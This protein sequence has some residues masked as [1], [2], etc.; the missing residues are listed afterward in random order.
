V[1]VEKKELL[2]VE[3]HQE[4]AEEIYED[5]R[6][7]FDHYH[8]A[9]SLTEARI[10]IAEHDFDM[11]I[12][13]PFFSDGSGREFIAELKKNKKLYTTP[14]IVVCNLPGKKAKLDFYSY[15]AD[16]YFQIPYDKEYFRKT[17]E[18][19]LKRHIRLLIHQGR[20]TETG[21]DSRMSFEENLKKARQLIA[22]NKENGFLGLIAPVAIDFVIRDFGLEAGDKLIKTTIGLMR[23]M[24]DKDLSV[25]MWTQK[26]I[27]FSIMNKKE[28]DIR[29]GLEEVRLSYLKEMKEISKLQKSPG[30]RAVIKPISADKTLE[31]QVKMLVSNLVSISKDKDAVPIQ[32]FSEHPVHK[33][34]VVLADPDQVSANIISYRLK[35]EG[36]TPELIDDIQDIIHYR[37]KKDLAVI[38]VDSMIPSGG[39]EFLR[40]IN[41]D[42]EL[43]KVP[44]IFLSRYGHEDEIA[45]AFEA[46]A[47]DYLLKP[48]SMVE[49]SARV[50]RFAQQ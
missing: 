47:E 14:V 29:K 8:I 50:K 30:L 19:K 22:D 6:K 5:V 2:I 1:T 23:K 24:C 4:H 38:L 15:G 12:V 45:E 35:K 9:L 16:A 36:Y 44:A 39:I 37:N 3:Q 10:Y 41:M 40:E 46:G 26:S 43:S 31:E 34:H 32:L 7:Y 21:I 11:I 25:A 28:A 33:H 13:N 20:D 48:I 27:L 18:E 49:L 17:I 42:P